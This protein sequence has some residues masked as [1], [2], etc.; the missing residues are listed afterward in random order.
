MVQT[1]RISSI[2]GLAAMALLSFC[3]CG[4]Q[5][6]GKKVDLTSCLESLTN[7]Q[8]FAT[9]PAGMAKMASTYDRSGGNS[10]WAQLASL[11]AADGYYTLVDLKGPGCVWRIWETSMPA[12]E[13]LFFFDGE[14]EPRIRIPKNDLFGKSDPFLPPLSDLISN[15]AFNY[16]PL[17]YEKSL[18]IA[19]AVTNIGPGTMA[20]Y[21]VNYETYPEGTAVVSYPKQLSA[22]EKQ[23]A[24]AVAK[25]YNGVPA[26]NKPS[27]A[28]DKLPK[29]AIAPGSTVTLAEHNG[30]AQLNGF[31]LKITPP[32]GATAVV[33][34][35][36]LRDLVLR[37]KWDSSTEPSVDSP[38]GDFFCNALAPRRF[39]SLPLAFNG[40][41]FVCRFPMPF[42]RG[43][44]ME[45]RN[46]GTAQVEAQILPEFGSLPRGEGEPMYFHAA[47]NGAISSG[48]MYKLFRAEGR[49][50]FVGCN[51]VSLGMDGSWNNL[52]G[53]ENVYVDGETVASLHGTGLEDYFNGAWYYSGLFDQPLHGLLEKAAMRT[54]QY[55]FQLGDRV[56]FTKSISMMWEFGDQN[57]AGGYMSSVAYWYQS[58]PRPAGSV[59]P[60]A[61]KRVPPLDRV[62]YA[63]VMAEMFLLERA[64]LYDVAEERCQLRAAQY[65]GAPD[66][67]MLLLR[68]AAEGE[69]ARGFVAVKPVYE[70]FASK[71]KGTPVGDQAQQFLWYNEA[72]TNALL[73]IHPLART[74]AFL[75]G[76][77]VGEGDSITT[78]RVFPVTLAP[79]E[80]E[81]TVELTPAPPVNMLSICLRMHGTNLMSDPLWEYSLE[82]PATWPVAGAG[83]S[84]KPVEEPLYGLPAIQAWS[85]PFNA[86]TDMQNGK[87]LLRPYGSWLASGKPA[88]LRRKFTVPGK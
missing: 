40:E 29:L 36:L 48:V 15:G 86:Y 50:Q 8:T 88:Y 51:L 83:G 22:A 7:L 58:E 60:D 10:D 34:A 32:A 31:R 21:H 87:T 46:D 57:K 72:P 61:V 43:M 47:W 5:T 77:F 73:G 2:C 63:S 23:T 85:F 59:I 56:P 16:R 33:K 9:M 79:G 24:E 35:K 68:S 44:H 37:I 80:H 27:G 26:M 81:L 62:G 11:K 75:D 39:S 78:M 19:V 17:P 71:F 13:W 53:D 41:E 1:I 14:K 42:K 52:E 28:L 69:L 66:V 12:E 55:R 25:F 65:E 76:K 67:Q 64:G 20:F 70:E 3:G 6:E 45:L 84:W 4:R 18:R 74:I 49:G 54:S 30:P 82:K 38:L